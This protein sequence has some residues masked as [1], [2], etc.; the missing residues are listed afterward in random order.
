M[1]NLRE[2]LQH[3]E[4]DTPG[5]VSPATYS[6]FRGIVKQL[7][8]LT[9][10]LEPTHVLSPDE[11]VAAQRREIGRLRQQAIELVETAEGLRKER[12]EAEAAKTK[13]I[14]HTIMWRNRW[15]S[16]IEE[17]DRARTQLEELEAH[18]FRMMQKRT[19]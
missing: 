9:E 5:T 3:I 2:L 10:I 15:S 6:L 16:A 8:M 11:I 14:E 4:V 7:E 1:S 12:Y 19:K 13:A 18:T 17:R